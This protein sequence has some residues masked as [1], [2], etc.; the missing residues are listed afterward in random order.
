MESKREVRP[1]I[2]AE[3]EHRV[4]HHYRGITV[5]SLCTEYPPTKLRIVDFVNGRKRKT[6]FV[7][8]REVLCGWEYAECGDI[9]DG[10]CSKFSPAPLVVPPTPWYRRLLEYLRG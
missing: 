1:T 4:V 7:E 9:N 5:A 6:C 10:E 3:C 8:G 2:C